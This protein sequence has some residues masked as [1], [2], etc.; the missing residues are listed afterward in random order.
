VQPDA[1]TTPVWSK[2]DR[3]AA[4][5][6][7]QASPAARELYDDN[8]RRMREANLRMARTGMPVSAVVR[9]VRH[10]LVAR[11]PKPRYPVGFRTRLAIWAAARL[12]AS[13]MDW[14]MLRAMGMKTEG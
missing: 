7:R 6:A 3:G 1:V 12:P 8:M 5:L 13:V 4:T 11:R 2:S 14:F 10:A 9:A